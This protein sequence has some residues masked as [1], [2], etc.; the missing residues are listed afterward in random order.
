MSTIITATAPRRSSTTAPTCCSCRCT[1]IRARSIRSSSAG[2]TSA[3][4]GPARATTSTIRCPGA[5]A[6]RPGPRPWRMPARRVADYAPDV[7]LVSLGVDTFKDDPISK[8]RLES[9]DFTAYGAP[10]RAARPAD[11]VRDGG[12]LC[13]RADRRSTR[14]T[15]CRASRAADGGGLP[16]EV[17]Q[18]AAPGLAGEP[19]PSRRS[20]GAAGSW[21]RSRGT[22][23]A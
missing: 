10:H 21:R 16:L 23:G 8:F 9:E 2:P 18:P 11:P 3:A 4:S 22:A 19:R 17:D 12:R 14:S 15:C 6:F 13:G 1:A 7:L 20:A 5:R